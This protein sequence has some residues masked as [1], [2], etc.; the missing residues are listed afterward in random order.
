[1]HCAFVRLTLFGDCRLFRGTQGFYP[2]QN[3]RFFPQPIL[4][5]LKTGF[6][7]KDL[8]VRMAGHNFTSQILNQRTNWL[9]MEITDRSNAVDY[10]LVHS[11]C[12]AQQESSKCLCLSS[13]FCVPW[14]CPLLCR[15]LSSTVSTQ[16]ITDNYMSSVN[17]SKFTWRMKK[18]WRKMWVVLLFLDGIH[19]GRKM[20]VEVI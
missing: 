3:L 15:I 13:T 8:K 5:D 12:T 10:P 9:T 6:E 7:S 11:P 2:F 19:N 17:L 14:K 16:C 18:L 1:M 20:N 4:R